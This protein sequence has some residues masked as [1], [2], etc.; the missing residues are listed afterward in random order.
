MNTRTPVPPYLAAMNLPATEPTYVATTD[1]LLYNDDNSDDSNHQPSSIID[2]FN[3]QTKMLCNLNTM[4][5]ELIKI[6]E[7]IID[8]IT[9]LNNSSLPGQQITLLLPAPTLTTICPATTF[10]LTN[11]PSNTQITPWPLHHTISSNKLASSLY[12]KHIPAKPPFN[13]SC[14]TRHLVKTREDS[15]CL[16]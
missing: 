2:T 1:K 16:P 9:C 5:I 14:L 3:L 15:L 10:I 4:V 12:K 11:H 13:C 6:V 8:A 7:L